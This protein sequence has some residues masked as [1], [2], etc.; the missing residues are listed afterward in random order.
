MSM[1]SPPKPPSLTDI[2]NAGSQVAGQQQTFN[3]QAGKESQQG[4]MVN[5]SNPYG[6]LNY[7]QVGT[8]PDGTPIYNAN[9]NLSPEQQQLYNTLMGSKGSAGSQAQSLIQGA[10]Y[11]STSP[12]TAIGDMTSGLT[13]Q[14]LGK[15]VA[16]L[17]PF[18]QTE[19]DQL[20]TK[21]KNQGL[22]PGNPAYDNAMRGLDTNQNLAVTNFLASAEPQAF[23]QATQQYLM[24]AQLG[25]QLAAFGSPTN[26]NQSFVQTPGLN[27]QP[28]NLIGANSTMG[29]NALQAYNA[30]YGQYGD[31]MKGL[32]GIGTNVLGA[33]SV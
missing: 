20:D 6:S 22:A 29:Q 16:S 8:S 28:A 11:G 24:P 2:T 31:L 10:N 19:R 32:F 23:Q 7:Q 15:E 33:L 26:P 5:Q 12:T 21:L 14:M 27:I 30:Q 25:T 13:S 17:Q 9:V 4:S 3:T 18:Q 1:F